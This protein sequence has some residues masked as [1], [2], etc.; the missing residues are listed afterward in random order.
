[1][2]SDYFQTHFCIMLIIV[3][4]IVELVEQ[5]NHVKKSISS[6][7]AVWYL[8]EHIY[9]LRKKR[10]HSSY[11]PVCQPGLCK[12]HG[13]W[14]SI[15]RC[16][17]NLIFY[18]TILDNKFYGLDDFNHQSNSKMHLKMAELQG[19][20]VHHQTAENLLKVASRLLV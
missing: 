7:V 11:N 19:G 8:S 3:V 5:N 16:S 14:I 9:F 6:H 18:V 13:F 10:W 4:H 1:M 15:N 12:S 2:D 20:A 17:I